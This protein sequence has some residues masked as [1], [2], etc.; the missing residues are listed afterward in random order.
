[1]ADKFLNL[2]GLS[3]FFDNLK[4]LLLNKVDKEIRTET[5]T[6]TH[7][8]KYGDYITSQTRSKINTGDF[9]QG[10]F[11]EGSIIFWSGDTTTDTELR[12]TFDSE[13]LYFFNFAGK[14]SSMSAEEMHID[15]EQDMYS[16]IKA[17]RISTG[18]E[19]TETETRTDSF[20][21]DG[22]NNT[23]SMTPEL[24]ASFRQ[25]L[26]IENTQEEQI[27]GWTTITPNT[28]K[29]FD[30]DQYPQ[31]NTFV[32]LIYMRQQNY[33]VRNFI[34]IELTRAELEK[35][36]TKGTTNEFIIPRAFGY[37]PEN[38]VTSIPFTGILRQVM[39]RPTQTSTGLGKIKI[40]YQAS[41]MKQV[42]RS[43]EEIT[44]FDNFEY[45][46]YAK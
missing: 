21:L 44:T 1:M 37:N 22:V 31:Y 29:E 19:D 36:L 34:K 41:T 9:Q 14:A 45:C 10:N 3:R 40:K 8:I 25:A 27:V 12:S 38:N 23:V 6:S 30:F 4:T 16:N 7:Y 2:V 28:Y 46:V 43:P 26:G 17:G 24:A 35:I 13:S 15:D 11:S 18:H 33:I 20:V 32:F 42:Y 5:D 39:Q